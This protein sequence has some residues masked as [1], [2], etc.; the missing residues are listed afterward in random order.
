MPRPAVHADAI[1]KLETFFLANPAVDIRKLSGMSEEI[2]GKKVEYEF[3]KSQAR[4]GNWVER[5]NALNKKPEND[6]SSEVDHIR[7]IVYS[8]IVSAN[9][10]GILITSDEANLLE[11]AVR[12][13]EGIEGIRIVRIKPGAVDATMVNAY[14]NLLSKTNAN[15]NLGTTNGKTEREQAFDMFEQAQKELNEQ[16]RS[17]P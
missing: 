5:R 3:I 16:Y 7:R 8:Q 2:C 11:T 1:A 17:V 15:L 12:L 4:D 6:I 10:S 13:L 14:M 9:E